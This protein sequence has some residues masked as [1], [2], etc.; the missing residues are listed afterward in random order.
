MK[1]QICYRKTVS[2]TVFDTVLK[3]KLLVCKECRKLIENDIAPVEEEKYE[4][5]T[6][7]LPY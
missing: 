5:I 3:H 1:C 4:R 7:F 2:A 6:K